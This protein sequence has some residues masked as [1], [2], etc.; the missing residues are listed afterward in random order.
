[1]V[2]TMRILS[3][4]IENFGKFQDYSINFCDGANIICEENG[5]GKSTF[6]AFIQA[7]FYGFEGE[8]K[9]SLEENERKRY[10]PWQGGVFGG[11]LVFQIQEKVYQISRI[12]HDK[13]ANDE[14]ELRDVKTNLLSKDYSS[15]IGEE[16]FKINKESFKR[17]VFIGQSECETSSTDDI[18]AKIGNLTDNANDMNNFEAAHARLTEI[19][20]K[21][22]PSRASGSLSKRR[23][24]IAQYERLVQGGL[25]ISDSI[26]KY[27]EYLQ[28]EEDAKEALKIKMQET[29]EKQAKVS[30][31]QSV[32]AKKSEWERLKKV[33]SQKKEAK[34]NVQQNFPADIPDLED[35]KG[36]I[37]ECSEMEKIQERVALYQLSGEEKAE[38][39]ALESVFAEGVPSET[40]INEKIEEAAELRNISQEYSAEQISPAEQARYGELAPYFLEESENITAIVA[41]WNTRNTKKAALPSNR[42]AFT[43][44]KASMERFS[45]ERASMDSKNPQ[46][47]SKLLLL[48]MG[49]I[50]AVIGGIAAA[51]VSLIAGI[52]IAAV[53]IMLMF[54]GMLAGKSKE[55]SMQPEFSPELE[56]LQQTIE[57]DTEFIARTDEVV[58]D[59]LGAHGK[60]FDEYTVSAVLQEITTEAVEYFA[61]QKKMQKAQDHTKAQKL[62]N[63]RKSID[64]FLKKYNMA[65]TD[66]KFAD[67]MYELKNKAERYTALT[68]KQENFRKAESSY[69][70]IRESIVSFLH[71]YGYEPSENLSLQLNDIR[72]LTDNYQNAAKALEEAQK[73]MAQFEEEN[74]ISTLE[75]VQEEENL[76]SLEELS[77]TITR[78]TEDM[79]RVQNTIRDYNN[80]LEAMQ[81][82][83][84]EWEEN[85]MKLEELK[86]VQ[87][88][89][90]EK[91]QYILQARIKLELAKETM[92]AKYA[93]PIL[94]GF[95]KYYKMISENP[96]AANPIVADH[97]HVDARTAVTVEE[98][99][100]QRDIVVLSSGYRDLVGICLR[101]AL[102]DAMYQEEVPMLIMD[103]PFANLDDRKVEA[104]R[105]FIEALAEKYQII[106]FTCSDARRIA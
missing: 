27:Q 102:V 33:F 26:E 38:I 11:Q 3:C 35:I 6:A 95:K 31:L 29:G 71:Q 62:E 2:I 44:L 104:C 14:F 56:A 9:R 99:G 73:E 22:T 66:I 20:N 25:G 47:S 77:Q 60:S 52:I 65:S 23:E 85:R 83:Y 94:Q 68:D 76:P 82:E 103:D 57:E 16:I 46:K 50:L 1:M 74:D 18:N 54:V 100:K 63:L 51:T 4:H 36:K 86:E 91:Y 105:G 39:S 45:M 12:F 58:A 75:E 42:A 96:A 89:E 101:M 84:D 8:R 79:E 61:L 24:E 106:Y 70:G 13:E 80:K 98:Y 28:A 49:V 72:D 88:V 87:A 43:A 78:L 7:M 40:D 67:N 90:Q 32:L 81:K 5:W 97:F 15:K 30:K 48:F 55:E 10:K 34:E 59:Y 69:Q 21:L 19:V 17:T 41:K 37:S 92:T 53:G 64:A 93:D